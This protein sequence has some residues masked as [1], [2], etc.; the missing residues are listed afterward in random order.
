MKKVLFALISIVLIAG[1]G[2][3]GCQKAESLELYYYKQENQ[4]GLKKL[5][6]TY[7][8]KTG[9]QIS[10]LIV[11]NDADATLIARAAQGKLPD[12]IQMQTY[13]RVWEYA[14]NG[15]IVDITDQPVMSKVVE[16]SKPSVT[17]N[18]R[19]Y[20]LPM[21]YAGIGII[22]NKD[23]FA[24]YD[25][26]PPTTLRDLERACSTLKRHNILPFA[27]LL[28]ENW[29]V[30][31]FITLVHTSLLVG[32]N[33]TSVPD[34]V[35]AMDA[36]ETSYGVVD[37]TKLFGALDFYN[38][39]M[40]PKSSEWAWNEQ[41][42]AFSEGK[43][44]MMVQGLWSYGAA[45][46]ANPD[47]NCGFIPYPVFNDASLNKI[48]A[49]IDSCFGVSAQSPKAKQEAA[50]AFLNWLSTPEAQKI[51]IEDYKLV[52]A[53]ADADLSSMQQPFQDLLAMVALKGS[54]P[55]AFSSYP[56][57][58]FED[59]CKNG[60]QQYMFKRMSAQDVIKNIDATWASAV[61]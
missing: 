2:F 7:T 6:D 47:L 35:A 45:I 33:K 11:P 31:H 29:S 51:W 20:A 40:D 27:G 44:A 32:E 25:I 19:Q 53:F 59:A 9:V 26:A 22:Y 15:Y 36:G 38:D 1:I 10:L 58:V 57:V 23:I 4:E 34:F 12:I 30:G 5:V 43:A 13:A 49:D 24:Q 61:K 42:A 39:N 18:G 14:A 37:T 50:I 55:W 52:P 41:V 46:S 16:N 28:A 8:E 48:Y 60:A 17:Y 56:T 54:Y 21:D 3:V